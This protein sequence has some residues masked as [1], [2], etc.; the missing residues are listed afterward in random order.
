MAWFFIFFLVYILLLIWA[1]LRSLTIAKTI[2][3][4]TI[5]GHRI[6]LIM[7]VGT[8][9]ATWVSVASVV[10]VPGILYSNGASGVIGW[11]AG[12]CFGTALLPL[13]AYRARRP[14]IPPRTF[15][16]FIRFRYEPFQERSFLQALV[17]VLMFVGYLLFVNI[18]VTGFGIVFS[19]ITGLD[20][21]IAIFAF[22]LL[23]IITSLGGFWS[24]AATD[25]INTTFIVLGVITL[26]TIVWSLTGGFSTILKELATTTAPTIE[27]GE[28]LTP[29]ILLSPTGS[30]GLSALISIFLANSIG[31][32]SCPHWVVRMFA[33]KNVKVAIMQVMGTLILL[34]VI[35]VPLVIVGLGAK[36]LIPSLPVGKSIDYIVPLIIQQHMNPAL[37]AI[38]LVA[39]CA[40]AISTA[41]SMLLHCA[42]S[43]YYD[44]YLNLKVKKTS[45]EHFRFWLRLSIFLIALVAVLLAIKPLWFMAMGITYIIGGFS[46]AFFFVI[47]F[48]LY[49]KKMN[50]PGAYAGIIVG[51]PVYIF[52]RITGNSNALVLAI[53]LSLA[54]V[55]LTVLLTRKPPIEAYEPYF[56]AKTSPKTAKFYEMI[57]QRE[58]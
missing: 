19:T 45:E 21:Q 9:T 25:T 35:F 42:T 7:G 56:V 34:F 40:A 46:A 39:I 1:N 30:F 32:P 48:G 11:V 37:G 49:W 14:K 44:V 4:Y 38:T 20:Y 29:G 31:T 47:F 26:A 57:R 18:Q 12:W 24:V 53:L 51:F 8:T 6:G 22:L 58:S 23:I 17:G 50:R 15:P 36:V 13:V 54:A 5:G 55:L 41:N 2:D 3:D 16:E 52:A 43:L 27:G 28:P 33:P 10:G